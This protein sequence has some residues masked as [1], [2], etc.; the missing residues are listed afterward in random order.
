MTRPAGRFTTVAAALSI[1]VGGC[2]GFDLHGDDD[3]GAEL[4]RLREEN[5][6]LREANEALKRAAA[7]RDRRIDALLNLGQKRLERLYQ[8]KAIQ[9][10]QY[11]RGT[12]LDKKPGHDAVKIQLEPIDQRGDVIKAAGDVK[13]HLYDLAEPG[14]GSFLGEYRWNAEQL[15]KT[16]VSGFIIYHFGLA[17]PWKKGPPK[18][19]VVTV[20]V[21]FVE[22]LTGRKFTAQKAVKIVLPAPA[23]Q[24]SGE[25]DQKSP[26]VAPPAQ[27]AS[28]SPQHPRGQVGR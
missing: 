7:E 13:V 24:P 12:D 25:S 28:P 5:R 26:P 15:S 18:H 27:T 11:T 8:V 9:L 20:R 10:G 22:Y 4:V 21:E 1:L 6:K 3:K 2:N 17:C 19:D 14:E 23:T 16:W